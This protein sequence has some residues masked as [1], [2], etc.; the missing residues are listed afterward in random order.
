MKIDDLFFGARRQ[1]QDA[2]TK[3]HELLQLLQSSNNG[4]DASEVADAIKAVAKAISEMDGLATKWQEKASQA[5][6]EAVDFDSSEYVQQ[7]IFFEHGHSLDELKKGT[8]FE[9][10]RLLDALGVEE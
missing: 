10:D 3:L 9:F 4:I 6:T 7:Q 8:H 5:H 2:Q 1:L